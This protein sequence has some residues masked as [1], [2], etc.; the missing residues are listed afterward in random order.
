MPESNVHVAVNFER[1]TGSLF[2]R[3]KK[4]SDINAGDTYVLV[5]RNYDK[6]MKHWSDNDTTFQSDDIVEWLDENKNLVKVNDDACFFT[7]SQVTDTLDIN[8]TSYKAAYLT[9]TNGYM[10]YSGSNVILNNRIVPESRVMMRMGNAY[11]QILFGSTAIGYDNELD[12][13]NRLRY[14]DSRYV[15]LYKLAKAY[16]VLTSYNSSR[17]TLTFTQGVFNNTSQ[18]G[19]TVKFRVKPAR[20]YKIASV[21]V[22]TTVGG[23]E[24]VSYQEDATGT[25]SFAMP[26]ADVTIWVTFDVSTEPE[27]ILG[28]VDRDGDVTVG[29]LTVLIDY[30]LGGTVDIDLNAAD[31]NED[32]IIN[33]ADATELIDILLSIN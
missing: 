2:E 26:D 1:S 19:E 24:I 25:Y 21:R 27:F 3:I 9:T 18:Q 5:S 17:G 11:H 20:G 31:L 32:G 22:V 28:D 15:C 30:I 33:I 7:M 13:F 6:V 23:V 4:L 12:L 10:R 14:I 29:D 8:H 16:R